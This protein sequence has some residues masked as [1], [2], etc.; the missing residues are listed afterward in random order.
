MGDVDESC[1]MATD[2]L[3]AAGEMRSARTVEYLRDFHRRLAPY[4]TTPAARAF[5]EATRQAGVI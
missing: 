4:R 2:S 5:E 3:R 1:S